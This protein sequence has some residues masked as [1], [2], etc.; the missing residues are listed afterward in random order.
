MILHDID[1]SKAVVSLLKKGPTFCPTPLDPPDLAS[2]EEDID[3]WK[4]RIRWAY[5]FRSQKLKIDPNDELLNDPFIKPP[6][7]SRTE[8]RA[9]KASDEIELFMNSV[10]TYL[11]SPSNFVNFPS[12]VS[13]AESQA[14]VELR[15]LKEQGVSVFLQ[16]KSSRF[17]IA[18]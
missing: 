18:R 8:R 3:D 5:C 6:W 17:V 2:V 4:E 7:Y 14:F 15:R 12:N 1:V 10:A 9:P 13:S 11:L 16:D